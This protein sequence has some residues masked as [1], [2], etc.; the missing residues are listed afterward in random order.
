MT[1][2]EWDWR[3]TSGS[4]PRLQRIAANT[5]FTAKQKAYRAYLEHAVDCDGCEHGEKRC[6][7]ATA[8]LRRWRET[9]S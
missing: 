1:G 4:S 9:P 7:K 6:A 3:D 5:T 8:L 2:T